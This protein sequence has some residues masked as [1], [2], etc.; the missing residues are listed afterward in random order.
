MI[1]TEVIIDTNVEILFILMKGVAVKTKISPQK[2]KPKTAKLP[3]KKP[4]TPHQ[5]LPPVTNSKKEP[6]RPITKPL[7]AVKKT[8]TPS[9]SKKTPSAADSRRHPKFTL[10]AE[11]NG[12]DLSLSEMPLPDSKSPMFANILSA[13]LDVCSTVLEPGISQDSPLFKSKTQC[14]SDISKYLDTE[15]AQIADKFKPKV[16]KA[17]QDN[18]V[19]TLPHFN[20]N[21][22]FY[23]EL[24]LNIVPMPLHSTIA[25]SILIRFFELYPTDQCFT[26][27]FLK[28]VIDLTA[29][30]DFTER[31]ILV[32]FFSHI[33]KI[34]PDVVVPMIDKIGETIFEFMEMSE[35]P[36]RIWAMLKI[37]NG[38]F[39]GVDTRPF[40]QFFLN[41]VLPLSQ[42]IFFTFFDGQ[43]SEMCTY[44]IEYGALVI[45]NML[46][47]WPQQVI[48]KQVSF[49]I[50]ISH[51]LPQLI[52]EDQI[53][54]ISPFFKKIAECCLFSSPKLAIAALNVH[55]NDD[56]IT[57]ILEYKDIIFPIFCP[58][59]F[60]AMETHW[61]EDVRA[62]ASETAALLMKVDEELA[63][64][65]SVQKPI[66]NTDKIDKWRATLE[67]ALKND[68]IDTAKFEEQIAKTFIQT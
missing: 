22:L 50:T 16:I 54:F 57:V 10:P 42:H 13:K 29:S 30:T 37:L 44:F 52:S 47:H 2:F 19:R 1:L 45:D 53:N 56:M 62:I 32:L 58:A 51:L 28:K 43:Y 38:F 8:T 67:L 41:C 11:I 60:T 14:L 7:T 12:P 18:I 17:I 15:K 59:I 46:V 5:V 31:D 3:A 49:I 34:R 4:K 6:I 36:M 55:T 25:Y 63:L 66:S 33:M 26:I 35:N 39:L 65:S 23:D 21:L 27:D 24:G 68:E 20:K 48:D 40:Q 64:T 61:N 9:F